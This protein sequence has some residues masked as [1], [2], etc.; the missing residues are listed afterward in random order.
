[1]YVFALESKALDFL[2]FL[3]VPSSAPE[4]ATHILNDCDRSCF[5]FFLHLLFHPTLSPISNS[6]TTRPL[7]T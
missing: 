5:F 7:D 3:G 6:P 2:F 1:M 4:A